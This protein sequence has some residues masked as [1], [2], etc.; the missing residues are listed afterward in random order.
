MAAQVALAQGDVYHYRGEPRRAITAWWQAAKAFDA[1][2][3]ACEGANAN[4]RE[5]AVHAYERAGDAYLKLAQAYR[6][7]GRHDLAAHACRDAVTA[8]LKGGREDLAIHAYGQAGAAYAKV[9]AAAHADAKTYQAVRRRAHAKIAREEAAKAFREAALAYQETPQYRLAIVNFVQA[10]ELYTTLDQRK[11][12][13]DVYAMLADALTRA[14]HWQ[15]R[16][17]AAELHKQAAQALEQVVKAY[18]AAALHQLIGDAYRRV[19]EALKDTAHPQQYEQIAEAYMQAAK[20]YKAAQRY[21]LAAEAYDKAAQAFAQ[22]EQRELA[23]KAYGKAVRAWLE[24]AKTDAPAHYKRM[25]ALAFYQLAAIHYTLGRLDLAAEAYGEAAEIFRELQM[26]FDAARC[27]TQARE[28]EEAARLYLL[29]GLPR[30]AERAY[31]RLAHALM[32]RGQYAQAVGAFI[33][34]GR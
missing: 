24:A 33:L 12:A 32:N 23:A 11:P 3:K 16:K 21:D 27:C 7:E 14:A 9:A 25:A 30:E 5:P 8:Y 26:W 31:A 13:A 6:Q 1:A 10:A 29:A 17:K 22:V 34:A 28:H 15:P 2:A 19:A 20:A 18:P 4:Q